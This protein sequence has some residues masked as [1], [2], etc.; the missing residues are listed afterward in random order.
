MA[1]RPAPLNVHCTMLPPS[2]TIRFLIM[3]ACSLFYL[4]GYKL[5]HEN[6][7]SNE[8]ITKG[9]NYR[10]IKIAKLTFRVFCFATELL[11]MPTRIDRSSLGTETDKTVLPLLKFNITTFLFSGEQVSVYMR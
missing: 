4:I 11:S 8:L 2:V 6:L 3:N 7:I 9:S 1:R 10:R 5:K